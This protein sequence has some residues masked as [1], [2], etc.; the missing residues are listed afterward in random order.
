MTELWQIVV[1]G[2]VVA[3]ALSYVGYRVFKS[4]TGKISSGYHSCSSCPEAEQGTMGTRK[5]L[6]TL[7]GPV[8]SQQQDGSDH[9]D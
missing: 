6:I 3:A 9:Q 2:A 5:P 1:T 8:Q 7:E 4:W